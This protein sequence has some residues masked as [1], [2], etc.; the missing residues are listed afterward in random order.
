MYV[1]LPAYVS[2]AAN[3]QLQRD[4]R[5]RTVDKCKA[6][7]HRVAGQLIQERKQKIL[8]AENAGKTYEGRDL[9]TL[10][11]PCSTLTLDQLLT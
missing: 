10:M 9:L 3:I 4:D 6:V 1:Y 11:C 5:A 2:T 7:I 8:D